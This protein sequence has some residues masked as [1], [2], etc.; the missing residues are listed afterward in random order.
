MRRPLIALIALSAFPASAAA[1]THTSRVGRA[2]VNFDVRS[3]GAV[4][5]DNAAAVARLRTQLGAGAMVSV[6]DKTG[7]LRQVGRLDGFLTGPS[8]A[9]PAGIAIRFVRANRAAF[10]LTNADIDALVLVKRVHSGDGL[11]R[12][13]WQQRADGVPALGSGLRANFTADGRLINLAGSPVSG[14][15]R[16]RVAPRL[17]AGQAR[18]AAYAGA[19]A[20]AAP[21]L[22]RT[23]RSARQTTRFANGDRAALGVFAGATKRV[24]WDTTVHVDDAHTYRTLVDARTGRTLYR[25]NIVQHVTGVIHRNFPGAPIGDEEVVPFTFPASWIAAGPTRLI[26][27]NVH[28]WSDVN[29]NNL[30][31]AAEEIAPTGGNFNFPIQRSTAFG[32][33]CAVVFFCTWDPST[34]GT[35]NATKVVNR[36]QNGTQVFFFVNNFHDWLAKP[37]I[38][39]TPANGAF[40]GADPVLA[41]NDDGANTVENLGPPI[42][43]VSPDTNHVDNAN[44]GTPPDGQSP[45]MQMYLFHL[46]HTALDP[47]GDPFL[48]A[49]GGDE[50]DIVYHEYTHGLSNR[51]VVDSTGNST[52]LSAQAG[53]MGEAWSDW[54]AMDYLADPASCAPQACFQD[55]PGTPDLRIGEYVSLGTVGPTSIRFQAIDCTVGVNDPTNCASPHAGVPSGGL[56][57]ASFGKINGTP[58]VHSDGEIWA[59][60]L[61]DLRTAV[62]PVTARRLVTRGMELSPDDPTYLDMRNAILQADTAFNG[63]ASRTAI[64]TVF[65]H[66]GMGYF[67]AALDGAD[68]TPVANFSLPPAPTTPK[69]TVSGTVIDITSHAPVRNARVG[70]PGLDSGF[71]GDPGATTSATGTYRMPPAFVHVYPYLAALGAGYEPTLARSFNLVAG[72]QQHNFQ[73]RRGW[74]LLSGGGKI[75]GFTG[76]DFTD[77]GCGPAAV[78]DGSQ[79]SGWGSVPS[80][81]VVIKLPA[82]INVTDLAVDPSATCGDDVATASTKG[83]AIATSTDGKSFHAA[84]SGSFTVAQAGHMNRIV[85]AASARANVQYVRFTIVSNFG[86]PDFADVSEIAVHGVQVGKEVV[87]IGGGNVVQFKKTTTFTTAGSHGPDGS[88]VVRQTWKRRGVTSHAKTFRIRGSKLGRRFRVTLSV[89][90]F[91]GRTGSLTKTF[92]VRDTLGPDVT[93]RTAGATVNRRVTISGRVSD[94]SGISTRITVRF[95]DGTSKVVT[96]RRGR[97]S[98]KHTYRARKAFTITVTATDKR[99]H[100]SR[101]TRVLTIH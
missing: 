62:G 81:T 43:F 77:F 6:D 94:P 21:S 58:E 24:V 88:P 9:D 63:G 47:N 59:Q 36:R 68:T 50:A 64:W 67:A 53:S 85:P 5:P 79:G 80:S 17:S 12:L 78:I 48:P 95:G 56:T 19:G 20:S 39:F 8:A 4:A 23:S 99:H 1:V 89:R 97:Y 14:V 70:L 40:Q 7:G 65:A 57:Y 87:R 49:N 75:N 71:P 31:D 26:G 69:G 91:V 2:D 44:M 33:Q 55:T 18:V 96:V 45:E 61:W 35:G 37:P 11:V 32:G 100:T 22:A 76:P 72:A 60:T 25:R 27:P 15:S 28:V 29:D 54:Y 90:D 41:Q 82:R 16:V 98:V 83:F 101:T 51:L 52:L 34:L 13:F 42:G 46:T 84:A 66:R 73:N 92:T 10:G 93:I 30:V 38:S 86:D 74:A 3:A